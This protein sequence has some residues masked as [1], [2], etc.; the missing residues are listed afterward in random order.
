MMVPRVEFPVA[1]VLDHLPKIELDEIWRRGLVL[2]QSDRLV[3][4]PL[5]EPGEPIQSPVDGVHRVDVAAN[6][7]IPGQRGSRHDGVVDEAYVL[8]IERCPL[9]LEF[10]EGIY[11]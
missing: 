10:G 11:E 7:F 9:L 2:L 6:D 3:F 8:A 5:P 4:H 1:F